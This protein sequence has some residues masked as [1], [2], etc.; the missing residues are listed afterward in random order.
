MTLVSIVVPCFNEEASVA[1]TYRRLS[2]T[3]EGF[4]A[5]TEF[6][7]VNDGSRDGTYGE[8]AALAARDRR[9]RVIDLSR[10]FGHQLAVT[11]GIDFASGDAVI[12]ID[13][14]LQDPPEVIPEMI[15][16][17]RTGVEVIYGV[18]TAR[19]GETHFNRATASAFYR[20][21]N[22]ISDT[23]IPPDTGDFRLMDRRVVDVLRQMPERA[24]FV[25]GM[26]AWAGFRQCPL[27]YERHARYGGH[28]QYGLAKMIRFALDG[29][30]AFSTA[31]L[32]AAIW[33]GISSS[34]VA[35]LGIVYAVVLRI[36]THAW[37]PGWAALFVAILFMGG[38]Q[39][40]ALGIVGEYVGRIYGESK[41]RPLYVVNQVLG[42][43]PP[44]R[45]SDRPSRDFDVSIHDRRL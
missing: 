45:S 28:T 38:V 15:R 17:W 35:V 7:F 30:T 31:P 14:D 11:A 1:E 34:V 44:T 25:R 16:L 8:L 20:L 37:V 13:A 4:D 5:E 27:P 12:L 40:L 22:R 24:R 43:E 33:L 32:R 3:A 10:N 21:I 6:V 9:V 2:A 26:V 42:A 19:A 41:R 39:L 36:F 18:R 29:V 23:P